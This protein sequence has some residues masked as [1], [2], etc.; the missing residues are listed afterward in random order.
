MTTTR[1]DIVLIGEV[2][3]I[4]AIVVCIGFVVVTWLT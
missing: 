2:L 1:C 4:A 3:A